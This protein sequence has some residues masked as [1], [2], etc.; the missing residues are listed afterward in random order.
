MCYE[1]ECAVPGC[2][3]PGRDYHG[4]GEIICWEHYQQDLTTMRRCQSLRAEALKAEAIRQVREGTIQTE[5]A[6]DSQERCYQLIASNGVKL[7]SY[8]KRRDAVEAQLALVTSGHAGLGKSQQRPGAS[9]TA[10][11]EAPEA[12]AL[13]R[14]AAK[15]YPVLAERALRAARLVATGKVHLNTALRAEP[16]DE[17]CHQVESQSGTGAYRV[18]TSGHAGSE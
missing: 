2:G 11:Q 14:R 3:R 18:V 10:C 6:Y 9:V 16:R 13:A 15:R 17:A 7:G 1:G 12:L 4:D 5:I 8:R